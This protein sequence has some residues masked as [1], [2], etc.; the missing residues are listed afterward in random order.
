MTAVLPPHFKS[1]Y[2]SIL[3]ASSAA[4]L[5][6][7]TARTTLRKLYVPLFREAG[8]QFQA[9]PAASKPRQ[10]DIEAWMSE[11]NND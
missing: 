7:S 11:W 5:H 9:Y 6:H 1:L 2:R 10:R 8:A 3:R 4:V